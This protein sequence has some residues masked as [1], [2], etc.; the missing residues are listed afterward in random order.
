MGFKN[1]PAAATCSAAVSSMRCACSRLRTPAPSA[2]DRLRR[3][4]MRHDV[5]SVICCHIAGGFHLLRCKLYGL[6]RVTAG[7]AAAA[8][9]QFDVGCTAVELLAHCPDDLRHPV[10][11]NGAGRMPV[12]DVAIGMRIPESPC[13]HV[14][15]M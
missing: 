10:R 11:Q 7:H 8:R 14:W 12:L 15:L 9:H 5:G 6:N 2:Q 1:A 4:Q 13:P 3:I